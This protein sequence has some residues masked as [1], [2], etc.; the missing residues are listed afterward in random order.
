[1]SNQMIGGISVQLAADVAALKKDMDQAEKVVGSSAGIISKSIDYM[2]VG[3]AGLI[4]AAAG[5][6]G[7]VMAWVQVALDAADATK[8]FSQKTGVA[9]ED[10]A[11]LQLAFKQGGVEAGALQGAIAKMSKQMAEGSDGFKLLGVETRNADGTLRGAKDVLYD[12]AD[13]TKELGSGLSTGVALQQVFGKSAADLIPTLLEGSEGLRSM[14]EM[15]EKLGLVISEE[16]ADSADKFND[17]V[18]LLGMGLTG[19]GRQIAAQL[20]PT[21]TSL[22]ESFLTAMTEGD[23]LKRIADGIGMTMK[24]L[25]S[26]I[27]GVIEV[28][29]TFGK[30][31]GGLIAAQLAGLMSLGEAVVKVFQGDFSGAADSAASGFRQI[32]S[33]TKEAGADITEGWQSTGKAISKAWDESGSSSIAAM[34]G[35]SKKGR[36]LVLVTKEQEEATKK[37]ADAEA[38]RL[39]EVEKLMAGLD[40][41]IATVELELQ[42]E[43]KLTEMQKQALDIMLRIQ[44]GTLKLTTVEK[45][46]LTTKLELVLASEA[47]QKELE[48]ERKDMEA[49][50]KENERYYDSLEKTTETL[51]AEIIKQREANLMYGKTAEAIAK[52]EIARLEEQAVAKDRLAVWAEES[53]LGDEIVEQYREQ[54]RAL[55]ELGQLKG[56]KVTLELAKETQDAWKKTTDSIGSSFTDSL[57]RAFEAGKSF[58]DSFMDSIKN[59]FK[60]TVLQV[61]VKPV[62]TGLN[63]FIGDLLGGGG[64]SGSSSGILGSIMSLFKGGT[65]NMLTGIM[66]VFKGGASNLMSGI[67]SL[68]TGSAA[69]TGATLGGTAIG[70]SAGIG[71]GTVLG[72]GTATAMGGASAGFMGIP[73]IGWII[74]G[75]MASGSAYDSGLRAEDKDLQR[76]DPSLIAATWVDKLLGGLGFDGQTSAILSGSALHAAAVKS[77]FGGTSYSDAGGAIVGRFTSSGAEIQQRTDTK[78]DRRGFLGIGSTTAINSSFGAA[79]ADVE[80]FYDTALKEITASSAAYAKII[81]LDVKALDGFTQAIEINT[82]GMDEAAA[83]AHVAAALTKFSIEQVAFAYGD[84]LASFRREGEETIDTLRRL[85]ILQQ[86]T[87]NINEFGG[88]FSQVALLSIDA[89]EQLLGFA[90]GMEKFVA[91]T[92]QFVNDYYTEAEK[93]G[94]QAKTLQ[95]ALK[96][97]GV[98]NPGDLKT[99]DDFRKLVESQDVTTEEGRKMLAELLKLAPV[100]ASLSGY[101][102]KTDD[103]LAEAA[104]AAPATAMLESIIQATEAEATASASAA[105]MAQAQLDATV[106]G[107]QLVADTVKKVV[108]KLEELKATISQSSSQNS[109]GVYNNGAQGGFA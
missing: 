74:A 38:K 73:V 22:S 42:T 61:L 66:D 82:T 88:I 44:D 89:K 4:T 68:F 20:L 78:Q 104:E 60:T 51:H 5:A 23:R 37:A 12:V 80:N 81:G 97:L 50:R 26:V 49:S 91:M 58:G 99:K 47:H 2:K 40:K 34:T 83:K 11:G 87:Q 1:M 56:Q 62:Q 101:L 24:A 13:A 28:F 72:G 103:T 98:A 3:F 7:G 100:F 94:M 14:A 96:D 85:A 55:R 10:V 75:M 108:E 106:Q 52:I 65:S 59:L 31:V 64:S 43:Q 48:K 109:S 76:K 54:A 18:E 6:A 84:A 21:M 67:T 53:M 77:V 29:S 63:N 35:M 27:L 19:V 57:F 70:G 45:K 39:A 90:G 33:I 41:K 102:E 86:F 69:T 32:A 16:T 25:Y 79:S 107:N 95:T 71:S 15:A 93:Y 17:T 36:E 105:T 30:V 92:G 8:Q 46:A 9:A